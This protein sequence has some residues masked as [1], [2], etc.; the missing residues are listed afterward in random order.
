MIVSF[1]LE[2]I[3]KRKKEGIKRLRKAEKEKGKKL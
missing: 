1:P 3:L 2:R